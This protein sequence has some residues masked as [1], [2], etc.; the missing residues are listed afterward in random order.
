MEPGAERDDGILNAFW[1]P[2]FALSYFSFVVSLLSFST[3][4]DLSFSGSGLID[5]LTVSLCNCTD[6]ASS[7]HVF[8]HL[9]LLIRS[10]K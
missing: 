4:L 9:F 6:A 8:T 5:V 10:K 3:G 1:R 7:E 2:R